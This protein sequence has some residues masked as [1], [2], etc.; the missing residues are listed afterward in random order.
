[1]FVNLNATQMAF[2]WN[3]QEFVTIKTIA[4]M[5]KMRGIA[6]IQRLSNV[7]ATVTIV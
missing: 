7:Q 1:M 3:C 6:L 4:K 2:V 5:V